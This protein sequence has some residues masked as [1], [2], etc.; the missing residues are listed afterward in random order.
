MILKKEIRIAW[1]FTAF[2]SVCI[3]ISRCDKMADEAFI[4][5]DTVH[6]VVKYLCDS[7]GCTPVIQL[8]D[9]TI[10]IPYQLDTTI[11][12][13]EGQEVE[14]AYSEISSNDAYNDSG[15]VANVTWLEQVGC[16]PIIIVKPEIT[17]ISNKLPSDP[18]TIISA[19]IN[20]DCLEI[21]LSFGGGCKSHEFVMTYQKLP[22]FDKYSGQLTLGHN[23]HGDMCEAYIT[24][25]V[26]FDL[27]TLKE[28]DKDM[29]RLV[30]V[31]EGDK[32]GYKLIIDYYYK[33]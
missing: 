5:P 18:F 11:S 16:G 4:S 2:I 30:L 10:I 23:S 14:I 20:G 19:K 21:L 12:L 17:S 13:A 9:S 15:I 22:N 7:T 6:G 1:L 31:K 29:I 32:E 8:D 3:F 24:K 26:S 28:M 27:S 25:T 33:K